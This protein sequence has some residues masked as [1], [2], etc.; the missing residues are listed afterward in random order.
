MTNNENEKMN[1]NEVSEKANPE[2]SILNEDVKLSLS[3]D[4]NS[5]SNFGVKIVKKELFDVNALLMLNSH[6]FLGD[7]DRKKLKAYF[8]KRENVNMVEV[9]YD[10]PAK[11][12][13][14][15]FARVYA[16]KG[17]GLQQFPRDIRNLLAQPYYFDI[18]MVN[19]HPTILLKICKDY[20]WA[21]PNLERYVAD[22]DTIIAELGEKYDTG[23]DEIKEYMNTL[24]YL[25]GL[26]YDCKV[27]EDEFL[28]AYK[29]EMFAIAENVKLKYPS[30]YAKTSKDRL[31]DR[32]KLSTCMSFVL[33]TEEH[34]ILMAVNR[35][36]E[37][38][39]R[40]V[41]VLIYD[42]C[43]VRKL[44]E[45]KSFDMRLL[46]ETEKAI[47]KDTGYNVKLAVK[48]LISSIKFTKT[49]EQIEAEERKKY[50]EKQ[51]ETNNY[52][53]CKETFELH[54]FKVNDP[55]CFCEIVDGEV[56]IRSRE[57]LV[58][59]YENKKYISKDENGEYCEMPFIDKWIK[60]SKIRTYKKMD[61]YPPPLECP[62][63]EFNLW[64][65]FAIEKSYAPSSGDVEPFLNHIKVLVNHDD[66]CF[67]Y[68]IKY[69]AQM[70]QQAG[71]VIGISLFLIGDQGAGKSILFDMLIAKMMGADKYF[72]TADPT[73]RLFGRFSNGRFNRILVNIDETK[74]K[75]SVAN[76]E[77]MKN[78]I[79]AE[80]YS[81]EVK[82]Q[83]PITV[84]NFNRFI[85]T[86]NNENPVK[87]EADDRRYV[88]MTSSSEKIGDKKYF[89]D[90]VKYMSN[91]CNL[92]AIYE[93]LMSVDISKVDWK[94]DR[95]NTDIYQE[96]KALYIEP[97]YKFL[98]NIA[99]SVGCDELELNGRQMFKAYEKWCVNNG[100]GKFEVGK[101][102]YVCP[103]TETMFGVKMRKLMSCN[104][105]CGI[106]K[107]KSNGVMVYKFVKP[108]L[109][110]F[111]AK[112]KVLDLDYYFSDK[113][114]LGIWRGDF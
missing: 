105:G 18:D 84:K 16:E 56:K 61:I 82:G 2:P 97:F 19:C 45:E 85:G 46:L 28:N 98:V 87:I 24:M 94:N 76:S 55:V 107:K 9:K 114:F 103:I 63:D 93:Y 4:S 62:P 99:K 64:T 96:N 7:G 59:R 17:L 72:M 83:D 29:N 57:K 111:L 109:S 22:R 30:V 73:N 79:T 12:K 25:G 75:E 40:N 43:L 110:A 26:P 48:P 11:Y 35:T 36:L 92:K 67:D 38:N 60:D 74:G 44:P 50:M 95:P 10:Y 86:T 78:A 5:L 104:V 112:R 91:E 89:D 68:F 14:S 33:T 80:T 113:E 8:K 6:P 58:Q 41:D 51:Y 27:A 23:R 77:L 3:N 71:L 90:L 52:D 37:S 81:H 42:G 106:E 88:I 21:C 47:L 66:K 53:A 20:N 65:G 49:K 54:N 108:R 69:L 31:T 70:F 34:K 15:G 39:K 13:Q 101:N 32:D 102:E 1:E 100:I